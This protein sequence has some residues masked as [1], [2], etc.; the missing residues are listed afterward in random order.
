MKKSILRSF[1]LLSITSTSLNTVVFAQDFAQY[2]GENAL[3]ISDLEHLNDA[4]YE[5]LK[6][7]RYLA[8]GEMHGTVE[9]AVFTLGLANLLTQK[10]DSVLVGLEIGEDAMTK[11]LEEQTD[12]S[13]YDSEFFSNG[14]ADGRGTIAMAKLIARLRLNNRVKLFFFDVTTGNYTDFRDSL[15]YLNIKREL[16]AKPNYKLITL[17]G[18]VHN[19]IVS[20]NGQKKMTLYLMEDPELALS[21]S[22]C[23][24][25]HHFNRGAML[26]NTGNGLELRKVDYGPAVYTTA[27]PFENYLILYKGKFQSPYSGLLFTTVV[28]PAEMVKK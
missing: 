4:I 20:R 16:L 12:Q 28:S 11:Y 7:F 24:L 15:M 23:S 17:S 25:S 18:N 22:T 27:T 13:I 3:E 26:N 19:M 21:D 5:Q 9:P 6:T 8:M 2:L 14:D 1:F 10:G